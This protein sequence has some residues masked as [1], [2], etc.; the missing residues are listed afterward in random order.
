M[1]EG[2]HK[3]RREQLMNDSQIVDLYWQRNERA[4]AETA[5]RYGSYCYKIAYN[6]LADS[7]DS[8]ECVND[9]WHGAWNSM[10]ENRPPVL[11]PYLAKMT[12]WLSLKRLRERNA[13]KRSGNEISTALEEL[14]EALDSGEDVQKQLE[15]NELCKAIDSFLDGID[16]QMRNVFIAR[17]WFLLPVNQIA[18]RF[19]FSES[20][21]KTMLMRTRIRL[22]TY[23]EEEGLC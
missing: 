18:K 3:E 13:L 12:R 23:L 9:T 5:D 19:N 10:P 14:S 21:V 2:P 11:A 7:E 16:E 1:S 17:Y 4:I 22:K 15:L 6:I 20:K 8:E